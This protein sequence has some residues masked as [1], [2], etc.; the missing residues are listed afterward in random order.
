M[1]S[2]NVKNNNMLSS[3]V[4]RSPLIWLNNTS[5]LSLHIKTLNKEKWETLKKTFCISTWPCN[6]LYV[7]NQQQNYDTLQQRVLFSSSSN[8]MTFQNF[9]HDLFKV[10]HDLRVSCHFRIFSKL[11]FFSG[12]FDPTQFSRH[13]GVH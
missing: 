13:S 8:S 4:K 3:H 1:I 10:F 5:H 7:C 2:S 6:I 11:S 9:F 12:I